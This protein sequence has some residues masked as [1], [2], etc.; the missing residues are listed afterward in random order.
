M[1]LI[2][3]KTDIMEHIKDLNYESPETGILEIDSEGVFCY[4]NE[5]LKENEGIW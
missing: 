1:H 3:P 4:S 2:Y 5:L